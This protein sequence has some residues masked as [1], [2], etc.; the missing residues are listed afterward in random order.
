MTTAY[1][2]GKTQNRQ[3][4]SEDCPNS[5]TSHVCVNWANDS[6]LAAVEDKR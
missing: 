3:I 6:L 2:R 1:R 5:L 4:W